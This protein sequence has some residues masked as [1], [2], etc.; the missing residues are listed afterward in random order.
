MSSE[1]SVG[2]PIEEPGPDL[3]MPM[4]GALCWLTVLATMR[5]SWWVLAAV[6]VAGVLMWRAARGRVPWAG[7]AVLLA[8]V[9][10]ATV[11]GLRVGNV[12]GGPVAALAVER[13]SVSG[14]LTVSSDPKVVAGQYADRVLLRATVREVSGRG[15]TWRLREP[16]V[17]LADPEWGDVRLGAQVEFSGRLAPADGDT[18]ALVL[19]RG[20]PKVVAGPDVW[21]HGAEA[22][23]S[24]LRDS[25]AGRPQEQRAL[26]PALVVGD[27]SLVGDKLATDFRTTGL[28]HLLAVSGTNL[29]LL[30]GF[31][32]VL[33][34]LVGVRGRGLVLVAACGIVGFVLVARTE[35]SVV[36]A[37]AMGTVALIG[38]GRNGLQRGTRG[39]GLAVFALLLVDPWLATSPGFALSVLATA[40]ILF[41]A[42]GWRDALAGWMPRWLAEAIAV[43]AAAQLACTP[44]VAGLS[45]EVSLVAVAANLLAAPAVGPATVLG[46]AGALL[47][48]LW[49]PL[50]SLAGT[51]A[52]WCVGW[53]VLVAHTG[54]A[55]PTPSVPWG[56]GVVAI[57]A[58]T[59]LSIG[60]ALIAP[61][62]LRSP[63]TGLGCAGL[64]VVVILVRPP[65]PGWPPEGW[66][67]AA[68]DVGQGDG[69]VLRAAEHAAVVVD[70]GPDPEAMDRCLDRL[71]VTDVPLVVL[72]HFHADHVDG[73]S[74]VTDGRSVGRV[75]VTGLAE[76][77][78]GVAAVSGAMRG[79][80]V[81]VAAY[82]ASWQVGDV[83]LQVLGPVP[84]FDPSRGGEDG[85]SSAPNNSSV[86]L[87][88]QVRGVR[89]LLTG[90]VEP[91]AQ[92]ELA[93]TLPGLH[94]DVLKVPHHGSRNQDLGFLL[95][96]QARVAVVSVGRDNDYGHPAASTLEPLED[97]GTRVLRTDQLGDIVLVGDREHL[98]VAGH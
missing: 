26:V 69:L 36:R 78:S 92:A 14:R 11:T 88:A 87:L 70:A 84:G 34:R 75:E 12:S 79:S 38:L 73:L 61:R 72:T 71:E 30:V 48:L 82:A 19:A 95:S 51:L 20:S 32:L 77:A 47:G 28:T 8:T 94:V 3:R 31:L 57:A 68:C 62:L 21:W 42:P 49:D 52:S 43:P 45:G 66:F 33:A 81:E 13:A 2:E 4:L 37:A 76:P 7:I 54:A 83:S 85:K 46:L 93:A 39:L 50:G 6:P 65:T 74:G 41:L 27:D 25:V 35:P 89:I 64:S 80:A 58:L 40:G 55:L 97:A 44:I 18:A 56:K 15:R 22:V 17:V 91:E 24:S 53:I 29:T 98:S 90:D 96:V 59:V 10:A 86:V 1:R 16:V 23:R 63:I 9:G 60:L 67:L 5:L